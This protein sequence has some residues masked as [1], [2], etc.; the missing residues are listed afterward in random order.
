M[1]IK[2]VAWNEYNV[3][4]LIKDVIRVELGVLYGKLLTL[5]KCNICF[6]FR[7]SLESL[8][9]LWSTKESLNINT[10][11]V[12]QPKRQARRT[13]ILSDLERKIRN[14]LGTTWNSVL[15][16]IQTKQLCPHFTVFFR[17]CTAY[18]QTESYSI[19]SIV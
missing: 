9:I 4:G 2:L 14:S 13:D 16:K 5:K 1:C 7:P 12:G 11:I 6:Q 3:F 17:T 8:L 10:V 19:V 15:C 18:L